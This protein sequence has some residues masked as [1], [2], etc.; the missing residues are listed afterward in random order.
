MKR[1]GGSGMIAA[2]ILACLFA[3]T[4][5]LTL[6]MGARVYRGVQARVEASA[7]RRV[8]LSYIT[9]KVHGNDHAGGIFVRDFGGVDAVVLAQDYDGETYLTALYVYDGQLMELFCS[10][11]DVFTPAEG[12]PITPA[13]GLQARQSDGMLT[14]TYVDAGGD[15]QYACIRMRSEEDSSAD[16]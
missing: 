2:L 7:E 15:A 16:E 13:Q 10:D 1:T 11:L 3:T 9:A 4:M 6:V 5:L 8:G 12:T 14:L